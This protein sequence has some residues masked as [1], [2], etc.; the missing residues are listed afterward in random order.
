MQPQNI[1]EL[2]DEKFTEISGRKENYTTCF[3]QQEKGIV[4]NI[5]T[6]YCKCYRAKRYEF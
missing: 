1:N 3:Q 2:I 4:K 5:A 6:R